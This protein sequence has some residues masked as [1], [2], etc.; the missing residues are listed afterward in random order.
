[1]SKE[2]RAIAQFDLKGPRALFDSLTLDD[3]GRCQSN[4]RPCA[5]SAPIALKVDALYPSPSSTP[6]RGEETLMIAPRLRV[7]SGCGEAGVRRN[8]L[9]NSHF[10]R[11]TALSALS[12]Q[13]DGISPVRRLSSRHSRQKVRVKSSLAPF[14]ADGKHPR[15]GSW[16][17][18]APGKRYLV[19]R[20][21]ETGHS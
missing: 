11:G 6:Q 2:F 13:P 5:G 4:Q 10:P 20:T 14:Y 7:P 17:T 16:K 3:K 12:L 1:M 8:V 21:S 9:S 15:G 19:L 18:G